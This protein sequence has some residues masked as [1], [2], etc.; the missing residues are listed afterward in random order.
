MTFRGQTFQFLYLS[1]IINTLLF[2]VA[3]ICHSF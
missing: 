3:E 1:F 2:R